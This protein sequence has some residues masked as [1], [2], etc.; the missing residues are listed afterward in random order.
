M[1]LP[2]N[3]IN[4]LISL[5]KNFDELAIIISYNKDVLET[6]EIINENKNL[7]NEKI[8]F[9][10]KKMEKKKKRKIFP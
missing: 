10:L 1:N 5:S 2:K 3:C 7:F 8:K 9:E 4:K 6:L